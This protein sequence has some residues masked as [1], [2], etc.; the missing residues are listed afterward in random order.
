VKHVSD[1]PPW[2]TYFAF[3]ML[4]VAHREIVILPDDAHPL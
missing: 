3:S 1:A 4:K 2:M